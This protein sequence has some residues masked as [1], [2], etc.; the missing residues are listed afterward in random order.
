[1]TTSRT[2]RRTIRIR[3]RIRRKMRT[4]FAAARTSDGIRPSG[5]GPA[6]I[7]APAEAAEKAGAR[8]AGRGNLRMRIARAIATVRVK[9]IA[10]ETAAE[11]RATVAGTAAETLV[12][13]ATSRTAIRQG[14]TAARVV[15]AGETEAAIVT[16][17]AGAKVTGPVI[18]ARMMATAAAD[19][20][21]V[22]VSRA[23]V[24]SPARTASPA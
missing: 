14:V 24:T 22:V 8:V 19:D 3:I 6:G 16:T 4:P 13:M 23:R 9:T 1:M 18:P 15:T 7:G 17:M 21:A 10:V 20:P 5:P 11:M 2:G 12:E